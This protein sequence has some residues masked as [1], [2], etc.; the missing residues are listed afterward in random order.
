M[1]ETGAFHQVQTLSASY[2]NQLPS[3]SRLQLQTVGPDS[4]R[5]SCKLIGLEHNDY[6][7]IKFPDN[8]NWL[9]FDRL[10][11]PGAPF[12]T[13]M[14]IENGRGECIAF[15]SEVRWVSQSPFRLVYLDFPRQ[16]ERADLRLYPR[17]A[18]ALTAK[19]SNLS[20]KPVVGVIDDVSLGGCCFSFHLPEG[21]AC[22]AKG[23]VSIT[24]GSQFFMKANVRNQRK[25]K[26]GR[27]S[28]GLSFSADEG[29]VMRSLQK[30]HIAKEPL[31]CDTPM[32][33]S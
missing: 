31:V 12:I 13:R 3:G 6:L 20:S 8:G 18:T 2:L 15:N 21:K 32:A 16:I 26:D 7:L 19:L 4:K 14:L 24:A 10:F 5:F 27:L 28:V 29:D 25:D 17:V 22:M 1:F 9:D 33:L 23:Q 11:Y 30:L